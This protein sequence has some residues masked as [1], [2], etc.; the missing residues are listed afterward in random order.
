MSMNDIGF[1]DTVERLCAGRCAKG[2]LEPI[3][4]RR[5]A[6][7]CTSVDVVVTHRRSHQFLY[8]KYLFV[9]AAR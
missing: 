8:D 3:A 4:G 7:A 1:H 9:R 2:L 6:Y 5:M